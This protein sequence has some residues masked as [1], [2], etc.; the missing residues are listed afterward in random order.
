MTQLSKCEVLGRSPTQRS[1]GLVS[2]AWVPNC[3]VTTSPALQGPEQI[4]PL[5][6]RHDD[7]GP[8]VCPFQTGFSMSRPVRPTQVS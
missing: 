2:L 5:N 7:K 8:F 6:D 1:G 4:T 3:W